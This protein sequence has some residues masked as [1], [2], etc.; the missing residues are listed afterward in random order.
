MDEG[1]SDV[2]I[3]KTDRAIISSFGGNADSN[4]NET[5]GTVPASLTS[6]RLPIVELVKLSEDEILRFSPKKP[7]NKQATYEASNTRESKIVHKLRIS[8]ES[9][10]DVSG[11]SDDLFEASHNAVGF[12]ANYVSRNFSEIST[13]SCEESKSLADDADK[14]V[15]DDGRG[16]DIGK[17]TKQEQSD[18]GRIVID[19]RFNTSEG[20]CGATAAD[21]H[22][23]S[24]GSE[25]GSRSRQ[26]RPP[27][28]LRDMEFVP[29]SPRSQDKSNS[30]A[31]RRQ[32]PHTKKTASAKTIDF[33][34]AGRPG[35]PRKTSLSFDLP[36]TASA[37]NDEMDPAYGKEDGNDENVTDKITSDG[38]K[39][40]GGADEIATEGAR[41]TRIP[42]KSFKPQKQKS[43]VSEQ[44]A[45]EVTDEKSL[46]DVNEDTPQSAS[47]SAGC[48][49]RSSSKQ[50]KKAGTPLVKRGMIKAKVLE[51]IFSRRLDATESSDEEDI[52]L[53]MLSASNDTEAD[54][55][56]TDDLPLS[57]FT[58][59]F[60]NEKSQSN[61]SDV[62]FESQLTQDSVLM[63]ADAIG[64]DTDETQSS[65]VAR[66]SHLTTVEVSH[67]VVPPTEGSTGKTQPPQRRHYRKRSAFELLQKQLGIAM[68]TSPEHKSLRSKGTDI[69]KSRTLSSLEKLRR[70]R[71]LALK[72][73]KGSGKNR[74][75]E[76]A[77]L[78]SG[79]CRKDIEVVS[80]CVTPDDST[81]CE[82]NETL[83]KFDQ[84][85]DSSCMIVN[86]SDTREIGE[87]GNKMTDTPTK[88]AQSLDS[89]EISE[90]IVS[91][92]VESPAPSRAS[93]SATER[94]KNQ[95]GIKMKTSPVHKC[96]RSNKGAKL[97]KTRSHSSLEKIHRKRQHGLTRKRKRESG[98]DGPRS[99]EAECVV[100]IS[101]DSEAVSSMVTQDGCTVTETMVSSETDQEVES[102]VG[103][104]KITVTAVFD[105][106]ES[107]TDHD[108]TAGAST[109]RPQSV[110]TKEDRKASFAM[111]RASL[112][113]HRARLMMRNSNKPS[114]NS[115]ES[116]AADRDSAKPQL[117]RCVGILKPPRDSDATERGGQSSPPSQFR[118]VQLPCVYS[119]SASPS[120]GIL[121]KQRLSIA[122]PSETP[123]PKSPSK[124]VSTREIF[125]LCL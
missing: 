56:I 14:T 24:S 46:A 105:K 60:R 109:K 61:A 13:A 12:D 16:F 123:S 119:P 118:P 88:R 97:F 104:D 1:A 7:D 64:E 32:S 91:D 8:D 3:G 111:S 63:S 65:T 31:A 34:K 114:P 4:S 15:T 51:P 73:K 85:E 90:D 23:S 82:S 57:Q 113:L 94:L 21:R 47:S 36:S 48:D 67:D 87:D 10:S 117:P 93:Q 121:K 72:R 42:L 80:S 69:L 18:S 100:I 38:E 125:T 107:D 33:S 29:L 25:L 30:P 78:V 59:T 17:F 110:D 83:E 84:E 101:Q 68:V 11:T 45:T 102:I 89:E 39:E 41:L 49:K 81:V 92:K 52:P 62:D 9:D 43:S 120:A 76:E 19:D 98:G 37:V 112:I 108:E 71:R 66:V 20:S 5:E 55:G 95:L 106:Q 75:T 74:H 99:N 70:K 50:A 115:T 26:R 44:A 35:R 77:K 28:W 96:L 2:G 27:G 58:Q 86:D 53:S 22:S 122:A 124:K 79:V 116:V 54:S 103:E 40:Q 6:P